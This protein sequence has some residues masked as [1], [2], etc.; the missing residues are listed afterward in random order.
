MDHVVGRC[1]NCG[2]SVTVP[3][4]W[5]GIYPPTPQCQSCHATPKPRGPVL[6]MNPSPRRGTSYSVRYGVDWARPVNWEPPSR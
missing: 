4:V 2:G 3:R 6:D 5:M 1:G